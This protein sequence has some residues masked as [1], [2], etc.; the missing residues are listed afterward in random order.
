MTTYHFRILRY[1]HDVS[2]EE[3]VNIGVVMW[4]PEH[5]TLMFRVNEQSRRLSGFFNNFDSKSYRQMIHYLQSS[6]NKVAL[7]S[8]TLRL[9]KDNPE[10]TSEIF[11]ELVREDASCFQW[12]SLMSGISTI[13]EQRLDQ[14]F[15]EFV[16]FRKSPGPV[17]RRNK[18]VIWST[19]LKALKAHDLEEHVQFR[20]MMKA[21]SFDCPFKMGWNNGIP[22][23]LEPISLN[24]GD[25]V[26][27]IDTANTWSGRLSILSQENTFNC[28]AVIAPAD[29]SVNIKA[30]NQ[31][32]E[33]L[34]DACSMRK[35]IS[36]N[37]VNDY[38]PEIKQDLSI[39]SLDR[40]PLIRG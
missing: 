7:D 14:L 20:V 35:V 17:Q 19:V 4:I 39:E 1:V 23:V 25:P 29:K 38:M 37:E 33:I 34:K 27:I 10:N 18:R 15:E 31:G 26:E 8:Q 5:S 11:Y 3:F 22:Q 24:L 30:Y 6:F 2:T 16:V 12:S 36:E 28:T 21:A 40:Q 32:Y 9:L 13:P